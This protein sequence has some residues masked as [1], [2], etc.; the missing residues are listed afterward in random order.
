MNHCDVFDC[1]LMRFLARIATIMMMMMM[2]MMMMFS[3]VVIG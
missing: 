2:M 1:G 3:T